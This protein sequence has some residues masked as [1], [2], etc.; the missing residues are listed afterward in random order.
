MPASGIQDAGSCVQ[1]TAVQAEGRALTRSLLGGVGPHWATRGASSS[2]V[3]PSSCATTSARGTPV[4][5]A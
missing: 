2:A 4:C 3:L 5:Q 1:A